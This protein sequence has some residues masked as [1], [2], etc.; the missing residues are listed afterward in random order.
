MIVLVDDQKELLDITRQA[1]EREGHACIAFDS[2]LRALGHVT[3]HATKVRLLITD[4]EM[5]DLDGHDL[6]AL[7]RAA[8]P[9]IPAIM[10]SGLPEARVPLPENTRFLHKPFQMQAFL[11]AV[12]EAARQ[13]VND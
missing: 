10:L 11:A 4:F 5:P 12:R 7:A 3:I 2:P 13:T 8:N 6:I 1:L 9:D